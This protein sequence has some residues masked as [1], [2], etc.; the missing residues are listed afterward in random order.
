MSVATIIRRWWN[1]LAPA[2]SD[3]GDR[4]RDF[5]VSQVY[6]IV[7]GSG[8]A[9]RL[10]FLP[11]TTDTTT[12]TDAAKDGKTITASESI[13]AFD[14]PSSDKGAGYVVNLN[15]TDEEFSIADD[16]DHSF[17]DGATDEPFSVFTVVKPTAAAAEQDIAS[18][19]DLTTGVTIREWRLFIDASENPFFDVWDD[20]ASAR[21][22]RSDA[23]VLTDETWV[24]LAGTYDGGGSEP[25]VRLYKDGVRADDTAHSTG[26]YVAME[27]EATPTRIGA[28]EST[29]GAAAL[30]WNGSIALVIV[31]AGQ[32]SEDQVFALHEAASSFFDL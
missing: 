8:D 2:G 28:S 5:F 17:G 9:I 13:A 14:T 10:F 22:G 20:S 3:E 15:G 6:N 32:L 19:Y 16:N 26:T 24:T 30:F 1:Q 31:T 7:G 12:V 11:R 18:R 21:I 29:A 27:N 25:G 4:Q 23:T